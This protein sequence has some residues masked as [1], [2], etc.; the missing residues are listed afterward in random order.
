MQKH[1]QQY[2]YKTIESKRTVTNYDIEGKLN[3]AAEDGWRL[4]ETVEIK[5]TTMRYVFER[6]VE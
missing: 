1:G 6:A 2:E 3:A 4:I 5:G